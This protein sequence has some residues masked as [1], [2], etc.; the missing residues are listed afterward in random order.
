V[1]LAIFVDSDVVR[2]EIA[3]GNALLFEAKYGNRTG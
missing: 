3:V 1:I 2:L